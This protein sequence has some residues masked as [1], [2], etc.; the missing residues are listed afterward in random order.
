MHSWQMCRQAS[1]VEDLHS[2]IF[3]VCP[4]PLWVQI[5]A[6]F[7]ETLAKLYVGTLPE[8]WCPT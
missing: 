8:G 5:H 1:A 4:P 7:W 3:D 6:V 2:E